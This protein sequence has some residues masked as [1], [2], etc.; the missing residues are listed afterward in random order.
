MFTALQEV[1]YILLCSYWLYTRQRRVQYL[2]QRCV[3]VEKAHY[4]MHHC[5]I[6]EYSSSS[7]HRNQ[8]TEKQNWETLYFFLV[9]NAQFTAC[10]RCRKYEEHL[11]AAWKIPPLPKPCSAISPAPTATHRLHVGKDLQSETKRSTETALNLTFYCM[12]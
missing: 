8:L 10:L 3:H 6:W 12:E 5:F 11:K 2:H 9:L 7:V 1:V 4:W